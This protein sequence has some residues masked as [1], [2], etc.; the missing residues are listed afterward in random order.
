VKKC[1]GMTWN[2]NTRPRID[3]GSSVLYDAS[4]GESDQRGQ[5]HQ[6]PV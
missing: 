5:E 6:T 4:T 1:R 3:R 2:G